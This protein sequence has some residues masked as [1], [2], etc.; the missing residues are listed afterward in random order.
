MNFD[1]K[2]IKNMRSIKILKTYYYYKVLF[3]DFIKIRITQNQFQVQTKSEIIV[4]QKGDQSP[5]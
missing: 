5:T 4:I 3:L 1:L 2:Q